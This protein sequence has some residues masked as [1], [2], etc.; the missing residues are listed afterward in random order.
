MEEPEPKKEIEINTVI[1]EKAE[2][3]KKETLPE[4]L[5]NLPEEKKR[6]A[7][8]S[9]SAIYILN[10]VIRIIGSRQDTSL[11]EE[12]QFEFRY[13]F[14]NALKSLLE[15]ANI[16]PTEI[17]DF[18]LENL[19]KIKIRLTEDKNFLTNVYQS[20]NIHGGVDFDL[21]ELPQRNAANLYLN[22]LHGIIY[23]HALQQG[24]EV[25]GESVTSKNDEENEFLEELFQC[26][27]DFS[28]LDYIRSI[29]LP[30]LKNAYLDS[31]SN[32]NIKP[33]GSIKDS[34]PEEVIERLLPH[35]E[36]KDWKVVSVLTAL[37]EELRRNIARNWKKTP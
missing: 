17:I 26:K 33:V 13:P 36:M 24:L 7:V 3:I 27:R 21:T 16:D 20:S 19:E 4:L 34:T 11:I 30:R 35:T 9:I 18:A 37:Y 28:G 5:S 32:T 14:L 25:V 22:L 1:Q 29:H 8:L 31:L 2:K 15:K 6:E 10:E 12:T 23:C